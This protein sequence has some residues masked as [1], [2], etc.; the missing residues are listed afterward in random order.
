MTEEEKQWLAERQAL[1]QDRIREIPGEE[2]NAWLSAWFDGWAAFFLTG[3][4]PEVSF[5]E[6]GR[7]EELL[8][9]TGRELAALADMPEEKRAVL[10]VLYEELFL[11]LYGCAQLPGAGRTVRSRE[12]AEAVYWFSHDNAR[13]LS[14][15]KEE[16]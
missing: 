1:A 4:V 15:Q 16:L 9:K 2:K 6:E 3:E 13:I 14:D 5:A 8:E 12:M 10:T 7:A 11:Q